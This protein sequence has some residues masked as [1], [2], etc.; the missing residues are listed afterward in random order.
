MK[1]KEVREKTEEKIKCDILDLLHVQFNLKMQAASKELKETHLLKN[2]R[3]NI[4]RLKTL[5]HEKKGKIDAR[6]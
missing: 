6:K 4:A 5:L 1:L 2:T 3:R